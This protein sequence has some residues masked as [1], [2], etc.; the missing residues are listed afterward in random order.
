MRT[1]GAEVHETGEGDDPDVLGVD[2]VA[3]VELGKGPAL[4][5]LVK[6]T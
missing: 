2:Y 6:R 3:A 5:T 1:H 4:D